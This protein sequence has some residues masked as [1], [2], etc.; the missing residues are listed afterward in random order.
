MP[1]GVSWK[2][3][4]QNAANKVIASAHQDVVSEVLST[5]LAT[6]LQDVENSSLEAGIETEPISW[7][8]DK[9]GDRLLPK[10][11]GLARLDTSVQCCTLFGAGAESGTE[12]HSP[13][14]LSY[15]HHLPDHLSM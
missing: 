6:L 2:L 9:E 11:P 10:D 8:T 5:P 12:C 15:A 1:I 3:Y 7:E 4:G 13:S 14:L